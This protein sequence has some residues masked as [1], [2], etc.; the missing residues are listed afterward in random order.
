MADKLID[1]LV[2]GDPAAARATVE[3]ALVA[4]KFSGDV[5]R[6]LDGHRRARVGDDE[7]PRGR[8]CPGLQGGGSSDECR[9]R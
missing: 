1:F 8:P 5:A 4:R 9:T 6:R 7:R 2:T 3:Q